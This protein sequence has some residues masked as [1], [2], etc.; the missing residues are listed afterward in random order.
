MLSAPAA[1]GRL[2]QLESLLAELEAQ[3]RLLEKQRA[4][5][6]KELVKEKRG[7]ERATFYA[8]SFAFGVMGTLLGLEKEVRALKHDLAACTK[9]N[10]DLQ[11]GREAA[12]AREGATEG[13]L[14][15]ELQAREVM[16]RKALCF[17]FWQSSDGVEL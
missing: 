1:D 15:L 10:D 6:E 16:V 2:D 8:D 3:N 12:E 11:E 7:K 17:S 4:E 5:T 9:A 13:K 14:C